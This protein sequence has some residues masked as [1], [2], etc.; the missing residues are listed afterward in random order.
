MTAEIIS[1]NFRSDLVIETINVYGQ[2]DTVS[3]CT[4][5]GEAWT[6]FTYN[7]DNEVSSN[8]YR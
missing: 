8:G 6:D 7:Q 4:V 2:S 5:D 1:D 3:N